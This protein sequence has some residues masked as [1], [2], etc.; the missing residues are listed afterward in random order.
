MAIKIGHASISENGTVNGNAGDQTMREVCTRDWYAK[1]WNVVLRPKSATVA[2]KMVKACKAGCANDTIGYSQATR[3]TAHTEAKKVG[4]DL[5]KIKTKCNTD[6]SAFMTLCAIAAGVKKL[7]YTDNAPTTS[8]MRK[9]F[10][11]TGEFDV[12][13]DSK[14]LTSDKYLKAGDVIVKEGSH[15]V[16][17]LEDGSGVSSTPQK[18]ATGCYKACASN[19]TS[20]ADALESIGVDGSKTN[21]TKI[22]KANGITNYTGTADQNGKLLK[23]LKTGKLKKA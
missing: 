8:T 17:A 4:Y 20:I 22:A 19:H 6:C 5:S 18:S 1:G 10:A 9:A 15:T 11:A 12:L 16:M 13:T 23:L 7:E 2:E 3:N 21:R 14:Y